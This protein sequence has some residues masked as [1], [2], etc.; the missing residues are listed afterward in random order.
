MRSTS[1]AGR[2][3]RHLESGVEYMVAQEQVLM[4]R[5]PRR[6][7]IEY[8]VVAGDRIWFLRPR[9]WDGD[10]NIGVPGQ[11]TAGGARAITIRRRAGCRRAQRFRHT[12]GAETMN[13]PNIVSLGSDFRSAPREFWGTRDRAKA[14]R[15]ERVRAELRALTR[16]PQR[17][18]EALPAM[19]PTPAGGFSLHATP[20]RASDA[21]GRSVDALLEHLG[22][23]R[24]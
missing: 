19:S 5:D 21:R 17:K 6:S 10:V 11:I 3:L 14:A 16:E 8:F 1:T 24:R 4:E 9:G 20:S 15:E 2:R 12:R 13:D 18:F 23:R 7:G 22:R